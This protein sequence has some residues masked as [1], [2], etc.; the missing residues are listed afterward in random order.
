MKDKMS[1]EEYKEF[2]STKNKKT[3][4]GNKRVKYGGRW[5]H[6]RQEANYAIK[7]DFQKMEGQV[8]SIVPQFK[9]SL[10]VCGK[11]I[12]SYI[13]DFRVDY[14]D[15]HTEV[16]D[17]KGHPTDLFKLKWAIFCGLLEDGKIE[18]LPKNTQAFI[19]KFDPKIGFIKRKIV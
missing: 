19:V 2:I 17:V 14:K 4:L 8:I 13:L 18:E 15:G 5:Y 12:C 6:S 1:S 3:K 11:H 9:V 7:L 16:I 10:K